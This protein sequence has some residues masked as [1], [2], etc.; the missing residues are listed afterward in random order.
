MSSKKKKKEEEQQQKMMMEKWMNDPAQEMKDGWAVLVSGLQED[1]LN[2]K[3]RGYSRLAS[4]G[5]AAAEYRH[6]FASL[7]TMQTVP[8]IVAPLHLVRRY[9]DL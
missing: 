5:A 1:N 9:S 8:A 7:T 2:N 3:L 6:V 4:V